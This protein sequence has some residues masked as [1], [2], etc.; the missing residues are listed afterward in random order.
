MSRPL[1]LLLFLAATCV[2]ACKQEIR[3]ACGYDGEACCGNRQCEASLA[4][5]S[6]GRC[7]ACGAEGAVCCAGEGCGSGLRC[8]DGLCRCAAESDAQLCAR[9]GKNCGEVSGTDTCR[10]RR[11]VV[12]GACTLPETCGGGDEP[13]VCACEPETDRQLCARL[14]AECGSLSATDNCGDDRGVDC[15]SCTSPLACGV[16][17]QPNACGC[18]ETEAQLCERLDKECGELTDFDSCGIERSVSCGGCAEPLECGARGFANLCRC[19]ET[20]AEICERRGAQCG[21]VATLDVCG[22]PRSVDCGDCADFLACGGSGTANRCEVGWALVSTPITENLSGIWGSAGD[23]IWAI[24]DQGSLWRWQGAS[25]SLEHTVAGAAFL[26]IDGSTADDVWVVGHASEQLDGI[27]VHWDGSTW[28]TATPPFEVSNLRSV[29]VHS[30][31]EVWAVGGVSEGL[32]IRWDGSAWSALTLP[33]NTK[34]LLGVWG[35]HADDVWAVG[36]E[37]TLLHWDGLTWV[38]HQMPP[39][40]LA[41]EHLDGVWGS[42]SDDVWAVG[43]MGLI[44]HWDGSSWML[45]TSPSLQWLTA[46]RGAS[47]QDVW[48][49]GSYG[50]VLRR[51]GGG[52]WTVQPTATEDTVLQ[53]VWGASVNDVWA[54]GTEGVIMRR[55]E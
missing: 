8:A 33:P 19:P 28:S 10:G 49:V 31:Q 2:L 43:S 55:L 14:G 21:P 32:A 25:W 47:A 46:V 29:W 53:G 52:A 23:D 30:P 50:T 41:I 22:K 13:N 40:E 18:P 36:N 48:A 26:D 39:T 1:S 7:R 37:R 34:S 11:T 44:L 45:M 9:L 4:C 54:V 42:A 20:D 24:T 27:V 38:R 5:A 12:C 51:Q 16:S 6:D 35:M 17:V 3:A 15:G